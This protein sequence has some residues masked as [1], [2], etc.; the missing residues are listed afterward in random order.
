MHLCHVYGQPKRL[1]VRMDVSEWPVKQYVLLD[2][3]ADKKYYFPAST[4]ANMCILLN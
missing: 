2:N 1:D 4:I 3:L